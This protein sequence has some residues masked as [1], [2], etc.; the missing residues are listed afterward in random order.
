MKHYLETLR[1]C[2]NCH[3]TLRAS[4]LVEDCLEGTR[5]WSDGKLD[6]HTLPTGLNYVRCPVCREPFKLTDAP[7][8]DWLKPTTSRAPSAE[9][10]NAAG[11]RQLIERAQ[12]KHDREEEKQLRIDYWLHL[13]DGMRNGHLR[14][15][16][17]VDEAWQPARDQNLALLANLLDETV[18]DERLRKAELLRERGRCDEALK[19]LK[20]L[21]PKLQ[22]AASQIATHAACG[23]DALFGLD[24]SSGRW[25]P[26]A[27][28]RLPRGGI[29]DIVRLT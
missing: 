22:W 18:P 20:G 24:K 15:R 17:V 5:F 10:L 1:D 11:F 21:P 25:Q 8:N 16:P 7:K 23:N 27:P 28:I 14:L 26:I 29:D 19:M 4:N 12:A 3:S 2:P 13:N 6:T 9:W